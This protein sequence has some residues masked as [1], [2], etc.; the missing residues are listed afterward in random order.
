ME[1]LRDA[2]HTLVTEQQELSQKAAHSTLSLGRLNQRLI[3]MERYF[4]A[5]TRKG[6]VPQDEGGGAEQRQD[7][8]N[9]EEGEE[10]GV[11]KP[12]MSESEDKEEVV[13]NESNSAISTRYILLEPS[14]I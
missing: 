6:V 14:H 4:L 12:D 7:S 5:L 9:G 8:E 3:I 11:V 13:V 1:H 10:G 2:L